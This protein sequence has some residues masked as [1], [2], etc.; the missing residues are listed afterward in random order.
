MSRK[1]QI[2]NNIFHFLKERKF[3][4]E[5]SGLPT[6]EITSED[7]LNL[8]DLL[9]WSFI[10]SHGNLQR[11]SFLILEEEVATRTPGMIYNPITGKWIL[12]GSLMNEYFENQPK[13]G[14]ENNVE[15]K[16]TDI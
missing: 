9:F 3:I 10:P 7:V 15:S 1:G 4:L 11:V 2:S 12:L 8:V 16:T 14:G 6:Q 5:D 13:E